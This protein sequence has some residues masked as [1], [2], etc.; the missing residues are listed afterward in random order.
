MATTILDT[1]LAQLPAVPTSALTLLSASTDE[2]S[3]HV[4]LAVGR[5]PFFGTDLAA[6]EGVVEFHDPASL[7]EEY[8]RE[9]GYVSRPVTIYFGTETIVVN[10]IY[11]EYHL[12]EGHDFSRSFLSLI[13]AQRTHAGSMVSLAADSEDALASATVTARGLDAD[14]SPQSCTFP[15]QAEV[16]PD[17]GTVAIDVDALVMRIREQSGIIDVA[18]F[19]IDAGIRQKAFFIVK[20]PEFLTFSYLSAFN[21]REYIDIPCTMAVKTEVSRDS[22]FVAGRSTQYNQSVER[23]YEVTTAPLT[24]EEALAISQLVE[25]RATRLRT[26]GKEYDVVIDDHTL[27]P[28]NDDTSLDS[29]KFTWRFSTSRPM[30]FGESLAPLLPPAEGIFTDEFTEQYL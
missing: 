11:C 3:L 21:V 25:S 17:T 28:D 6:Y 20:H 8:F 29:V 7:I 10:C 30:L 24:R 14:G 19:T 16:P 22:A 26:G 18:S 27:E 15:L 13:Y 2:P 9:Q 1:S 4:G 12:P 5:I 23:K